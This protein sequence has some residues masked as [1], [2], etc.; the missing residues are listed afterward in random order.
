MAR[1]HGGRGFVRGPRRATDWS[2]SL[3]QDSQVT[4]PASSAVL[5]ETFVPIVGGE[6]IIRTRGLFTIASDQSVGTEIQFGAFGICVV[7]QQAAGIGITAIPHP[8]T[9][10]AW[11][12]WFVHGFFA[13][14]FRFLSAIGFQ[15]HN[16]AQFPID[17]KAMRKV[18]EDERVVVVIENTGATTGLLVSDSFRFLTKVH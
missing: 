7:T 13:E 17:S 11:G 8:S 3:V 10:A 18:D 14:E 6:T 15:P 16:A 2:A 1:R 4:V 9:D 5:L 12:G